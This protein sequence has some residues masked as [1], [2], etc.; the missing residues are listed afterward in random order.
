MRTLNNGAAGIVSGRAAPS[1]GA[2]DGQLSCGI[3]LEQIDNLPTAT[4]YWED[5]FYKA[6]FT[7]AEI[8]Y[9][10][11]QER[12]AL[13][14]AARWCAKE[15]LKKCAPEFFSEEMR[16]L[17]VVLGDSGQPSLNH[18]GGEGAR[19]LP[20]AVSISHTPTAAIAVV[21][22]A[23]RETG[24]HTVVAPASAEGAPDSSREPT[25]RP[26]HR[27]HGG[28]DFLQTLLALAAL[29]VATLA[30]LKAYQL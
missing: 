17:E 21:M 8:A 13:H 2:V 22:K 4:D 26:S 19:R 3:D 23:G 29:G 28:W 12:P 16:N 11:M 27:L 10:L 25:P 18:L 24:R 5:A 15:A 20:H 1:A 7:P 9:C 6:S 14:F 30:L